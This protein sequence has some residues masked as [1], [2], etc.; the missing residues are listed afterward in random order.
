MKKPTCNLLKAPIATQTGMKN[1]TYQFLQAST[2]R[3]SLDAASQKDMENL[4]HKSLTAPLAKQKDM[5]NLTLR[6]VSVTVGRHHQR[7][8]CLHRMSRMCQE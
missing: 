5:E 7:P 6:L 3:R 4:T 8:E 1:L 2:G